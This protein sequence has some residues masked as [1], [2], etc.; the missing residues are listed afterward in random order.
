MTKLEKRIKDV[1]SWELRKGKS[2][3]LRHLEG[4]KPLTAREAVLAKCYECNCGYPEGKGDC[5]ILECPLHD[6]MPFKEGGARKSRIVSEELKQAAS[7]R[8]KEKN[9]SATGDSGV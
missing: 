6:F 7:K 9:L 3:L 5:L 1:K 8:M 2:E 4:G